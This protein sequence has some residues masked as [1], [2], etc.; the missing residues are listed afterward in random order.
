MKILKTGR[1]GNVL[2]NHRTIRDILEQMDRTL[3]F[4]ETNAAAVSDTY[5]QVEFAGVLRSLIRFFPASGRLLEIGAGSVR[6][7]FH[8]VIRF[9]PVFQ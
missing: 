5:E 6:E 9:H 7:T 1:A 2:S 4:Y 8:V 3:D